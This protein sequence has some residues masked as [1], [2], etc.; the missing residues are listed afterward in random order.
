[1]TEVTGYAASD[2]RDRWAL[3]LALSFGRLGEL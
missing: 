2:P 1:V 3:S